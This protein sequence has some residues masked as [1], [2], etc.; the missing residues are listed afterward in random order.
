M[1]LSPTP[2]TGAGHLKTKSLLKLCSIR[3]RDSTA[4][5]GRIV[6]QAI[7]MSIARVTAHCTGYG[8]LLIMLFAIWPG[9]WDWFLNPARG[10]VLL[11]WA[12]NLS[13]TVLRWQQ[14]NLRGRWLDLEASKPPSGGDGSIGVMRP[15][16][17]VSS[18]V[19]PA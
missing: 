4:G 8:I 14:I 12:A 15:G 7:R 11:D 6:K 17:C 9:C 18:E 1:A 13:D 16:W 2:W 5:N 10:R 19:R 3:D